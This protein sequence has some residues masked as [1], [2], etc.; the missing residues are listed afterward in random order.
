MQA[1]T[2]WKAVTM[3][4]ANFLDEIV[5]LL[6]DGGFRFCVIGGQAVNAYVDPL[7]SLDL[8]LVIAVDQI[9][10]LVKEVQRRFQVEHHPHS[11]NISTPGSKL[12]VQLQTDPRYFDF[13]DRAR[14]RPVL[15]VDLPVASMEDVLQG[16]V[17]AALAEERRPSK[18]RKDLLDIERLIEAYPELRSKVPAEILS[19]LES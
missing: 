12:R 1:V 13:V 8:D 17:W 15:D 7:I 5:A 18:R 14:T 2:I 11:V 19:R 16:K 9:S 6:R 3:D 4:R 10:S